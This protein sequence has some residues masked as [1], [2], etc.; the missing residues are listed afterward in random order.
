MLALK[1]HGCGF[2]SKIHDFSSLGM[3][4]LLLE[5]VLSPIRDLFTTA[6]GMSA[7]TAP[8]VL[9]SVSC[10]LLRVI[11]SKN[12]SKDCWLPPSFGRAS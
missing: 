11:G 9:V 6:Q 3:I 2:S 5:R 1:S 10:W 12:C 8:L 7:A 4:S